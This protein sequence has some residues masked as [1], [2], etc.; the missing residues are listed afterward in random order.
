M[1]PAMPR[2]VAIVQSSWPPRPRFQS[3]RDQ[4]PDGR[5][6]PAARPRLPWL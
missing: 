3:R 6:L 2:G 5:R 4:F 1:F